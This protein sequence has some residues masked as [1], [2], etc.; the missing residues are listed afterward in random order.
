[1]IPLMLN[2][3]AGDGTAG[4]ADGPSATARFKDPCGV[5]V[6]TAG[7]FYVADAGNH[8]V[9]M[10]TPA[11]MVSTI[12]GDGTAGFADGPSATATLLTVCA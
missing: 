9:R 1:M 11:G 3:I 2:T 5:C 10:I 12:A 7:N 8:C 6:S 4:F